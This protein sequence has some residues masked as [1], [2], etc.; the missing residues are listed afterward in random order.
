MKQIIERNLPL[1]DKYKLISITRQ[2]LETMEGIGL[3]C[4]NCNVQII[5]IAEI[6]NQNGKRFN[7]GLDCMKTLTSALMNLSFAQ[8]EEYAFNSTLR[9]YNLSLKA[10]KAEINKDFA[11]IDYKD[12]NNKPV[13]KQ[14]F[15]MNLERFKFNLSHFERDNPI[16]K[17]VNEIFESIQQGEPFKYDGEYSLRYSNGKLKVYR[18]EQLMRLTE[19]D[20][21]ERIIK[22]TLTT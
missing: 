8:E 13:S 22:R 2:T 17:R 20:I 10:D 9:F 7:V 21:A 12:K 1:S 18:G 15:L 6:V 4:D 16:S 14:E 11:V 3:I 19:W 5:N